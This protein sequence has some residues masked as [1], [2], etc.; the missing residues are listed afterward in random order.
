MAGSSCHPCGALLFLAAVSVYVPN[1]V[2]SCSQLVVVA[3]RD[4]QVQDRTG[5]HC[6]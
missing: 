3:S 6:E 2:G 5:A 1:A 4:G